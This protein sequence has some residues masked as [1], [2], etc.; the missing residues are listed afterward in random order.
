MFL[1][2]NNYKTKMFLNR[3]TFNLTQSIFFIKL[4]SQPPHN[5]AVGFQNIKILQ[6]ILFMLLEYFSKHLV[7]V[8]TTFLQF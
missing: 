4:K 8:H 7:N 2:E 3:N 6:I 5:K 1:F